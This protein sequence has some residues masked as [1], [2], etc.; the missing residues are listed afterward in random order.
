MAENGYFFMSING[1]ASFIQHISADVLSI[2]PEAFNAG[3]ALSNHLEI[4]IEIPLVGSS[5]I[6]SGAY[7]KEGENTP[8]TGETDRAVVVSSVD[9][10]PNDIDKIL[11]TKTTP[12]LTPSLTHDNPFEMVSVGI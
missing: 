8:T 5:K 3:M 2:T 4:D 11:A 9:L 10:R 12:S 1:A 7:E 6:D